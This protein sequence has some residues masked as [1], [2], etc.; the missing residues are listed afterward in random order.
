MNDVFSNFFNE[1]AEDEISKQQALKYAEE[2]A[3]L[4]NSEKKK[5]AELKNALKELK[6]LKEKLQIENNYLKEEFKNELDSGCI[7]GRSPALKNVLDQIDSIAKAEANVLING[8]TGTGKELIAK[9]LHENSKRSNK[10][11]IKVN[12]GAIPKELFESE[13]FGHVK[14]AFTGAIKNRIGRFQLADKGILFLDEISEI[15]PEL[16]VKLLRVLQENSFERVG[17]DKTHNINVRV[18]AATNRNL[19]EEI[20]LGKFREDLYYR[21]N[22]LFL[23]VPPLRNR[24]EDIPLLAK[25]FIKIACRKNS[26]SNIELSQKTTECLMG[27]NWPGNIRELQNVIERSVILSNA[28]PLKFEIILQKSISLNKSEPFCQQQ[29]PSS[30]IYKL[31]NKRHQF[32]EALQKTNWKIYGPRGAAEILKI[33]PT[34]LAYQLKRLGIQKP[35]R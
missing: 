13:F 3:A 14:G 7:I 15:P 18:I 25:H 16:Q 35:K 17:D 9:A 20:R 6:K 11:F 4:Y 27:Y 5:K 21:L 10:P 19:L 24:A 26:F 8:E 23:E 28:S 33:K 30:L 32:L 22:V 29:P 1:Q 31:D 2:F 12:C 34:T